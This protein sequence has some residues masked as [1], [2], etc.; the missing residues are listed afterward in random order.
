MP[1]LYI[2]NCIINE[3]VSSLVNLTTVSANYD[4]LD[5]RNTVDRVRT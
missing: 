5:Y 4:R 2:L 1:L 3:L